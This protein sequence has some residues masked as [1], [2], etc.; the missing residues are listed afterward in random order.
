MGVGVMGQEERTILIVGGGIAGMTA[1]LHIAEAGQRALVIDSA[2]VIGGALPLL[3]KTYP[4][5]SCGVCFLAPRQPA[6]CPFFECEYHPNIELRSATT[7]ESLT[8][9]PGSFKARLRS[10]PRYVDPTLCTGCGRCTEYCSVTVG[11][12]HLG[13]AWTGETRQAIYR[14]FPQAVPDTYVIDPETC[15][16]C[17]ECIPACPYDA[18]DLNRQPETEETD[19]DAVILAPGFG[20]NDAHVRGAYGYGEYA[21][22]ITSNVFFDLLKF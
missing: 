16:Y 10:D 7:L 14:P 9:Q 12:G 6:I 13:A 20:P 21:D 11:V 17:G 8:G 5:D 18:I 15:T 4:T 22:V 3:D 2:P 19:V 1:A